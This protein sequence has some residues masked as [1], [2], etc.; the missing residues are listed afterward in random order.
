M[1]TPR[2]AEQPYS[3][4]YLALASRTQSQGSMVM[5][6]SPAPFATL[7]SYAKQA[8]ESGPAKRIQSKSR[9]EGAPRL[10]ATIFKTSKK[11]CTCLTSTMLARTTSPSQSS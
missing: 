1:Q 10:C 11:M 7:A 3:H 2:G 6:P 9:L 8:S 4:Y 5:T